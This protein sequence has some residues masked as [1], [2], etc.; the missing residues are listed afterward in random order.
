MKK[1][2]DI[3]TK[4]QS[5]LLGLAV[6]LSLMAVSVKIGGGSVK[7]NL[8]NYP[9]LMILLVLLSIVL[10]MLYIRVDSYRIKNLSEQIK[11][12]ERDEVD[13]LDSLLSQLTSRQ[14]EVYTLIVSGKSNKE[15][16][17]ALFIEQSTLKSHIN[18][19]YK[20]LNIKSRKELKSKITG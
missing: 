19:I 12:Q 17:A 13:G 15:I 5:Y 11:T 2:I 10:V 7:L 8:K 3:L 6:F 18:Q 4:N 1:A 20:K 14:K 9:I 16:M